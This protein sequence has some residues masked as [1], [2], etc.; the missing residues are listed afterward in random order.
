MT[1]K[2]PEIGKVYIHKNKPEKYGTIIILTIRTISEIHFDYDIETKRH[3]GFIYTYKPFQFWQKFAEIPNQEQEQEQ[4]KY[5]N[6][7]YEFQCVVCKSFVGTS[8]PHYYERKRCCGCETPEQEPQVEDDCPNEQ[9]AANW[10]MEQEDIVEDDKK[11]DEVDEALKRMHDF[12]VDNLNIEMPDGRLG[13]RELRY[14]IS[15]RYD[16]YKELFDLYVK[17]ENAL[18]ENKVNQMKEKLKDFHNNKFS[19]RYSKSKNNI[20]KHSIKELKE[21]LK[22]ECITIDD[23]NLCFDELHEKAQNLVNALEKK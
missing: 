2:L 5:P 6:C 10:N 7:R 23:L 17:L 20:L 3:D 18:Q 1:N 14:I 9:A 8:F 15:S 16:N 11:V 21:V 13:E 4:K 19:V 12:I 22:T